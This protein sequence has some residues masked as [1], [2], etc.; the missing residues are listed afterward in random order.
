[1]ETKFQTSFIPKASL[2]PQTSYEKPAVGLFLFLATIAFIA[3]L[4]IAA[5]AFGYRA[6]LQNQTNVVKTNLDKNVKA[7]E[8]DTIESYVRLENRLNTAQKLLNQHIAT[9]N[10]FSYLSQNTLKSVRFTDFKYD[11]GADGSVTLTMNGQAASYNSVAYQSQIFGQDKNLKNPIFS[12][13]DLD[14]KGNVV[15]NFTTKVDPG[16]LYY[17]GSVNKRQNNDYQQ[18]TVTSDAN[19]T[20]DISGG[21]T[22]TTGT[23]NGNVFGGTTGGATDGSAGSTNGGSTSQ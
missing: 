21:S 19:N 17:A 11:L 20:P 6:Y 4:I 1:M 18:G 16:L 10:L 2:T 5:G 22:G 13:L 12:N 23:S 8:P 9:T 14:E 15:F 7:F 3:S